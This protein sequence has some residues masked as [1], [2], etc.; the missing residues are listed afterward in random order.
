MLPYC[1]AGQGIDLPFVEKD[2]LLTLVRLGIGHQS[3][4]P[5]H[6]IIDWK[7]IRTLSD[8]QGLTAIVLDGISRLKEVGCLDDNSALDRITKLNW[9][10]TVQNLYEQRY[11]KYSTAISSL[12]SFYCKYGIRMMVL[13]GYG[14]SQCY[15]VPEHRPCGDIDIWL[16][17]R[18][19]EADS[20]LSQELG[21]TV[22]KSFFHHTVFCYQ[23]FTVENHYDFVNRKISRYNSWL[24]DLLKELAMDDREKVV[25]DGQEVII[26][27]PNLHAL[28]LVRHMTVHFFSSLTVRQ[29]LDWGF[30]V[31]KN[32]DRINWQWLL[33]TISKFGMMRF[34]H[35][36]N[37]IC[38]EDLGFDSSLFPVYEVDIS[39][40]ER[41]INDSLFPAD[42]GEKP[43]RLFPVFIYKWKRWKAR[44][45]KRQ[46]FGY[47][48]C[49]DFV[50]SLW[51]HLIKPT[52]INKI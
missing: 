50:L 36:I 20:I 12:A 30:F 29:I 19:K 24:D 17:G 22:N 47:S 28:F 33:E 35:C 18:Y 13:K 15:P 52:M 38:V 1:L 40:K 10:V 21:I 43:K 49:R 9:Y 2:I 26:P 14:L 8:L 11:T 46:V 51:A 3:V 23:G 34:F 4:I 41:I 42:F 25:V 31:E 7:R 27:S 48:A 37:A 45:W 32:K 5:I 6:T 16:F 44:E 39:L